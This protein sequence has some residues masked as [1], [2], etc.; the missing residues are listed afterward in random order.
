MSFF[1]FSSFQQETHPWSDDYCLPL[2]GQCCYLFHRQRAKESA[3]SFL[4][5]LFKLFAHLLVIRIWDSHFPP[6]HRG[7]GRQKLVEENKF[8][9]NQPQL[10]QKTLSQI[11]IEKDLYWLLP[12]RCDQNQRQK[13]KVRKESFSYKR[14]EHHGRKGVAPGHRA[15]QMLKWD[16]VPNLKTPPPSM[17]HFL[18]QGFYLLKTPQSGK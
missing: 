6:H 8:I 5:K 10:R 16:R 12:C 11:P 17:T 14:T 2:F 9:Q 3:G 15:L 13:F 4:K 18:Q 7:H 1:V